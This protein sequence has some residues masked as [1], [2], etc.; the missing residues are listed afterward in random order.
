[1]K[2]L[3]ISAIAV[4]L[5]GVA[6]AACT[7]SDSLGYACS[8][9]WLAQDIAGTVLAYVMFLALAG[10]T[11]TVLAIEEIQRRSTYTKKLREVTDEAAKYGITYE[12]ILEQEA[13][14]RR[15]EEEEIFGK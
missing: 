9:D 12:K 10:F 4:S 7:N 2:T 13:E 6:S 5:I 11:L 15:K 8:N 3:I 14:K 1:M